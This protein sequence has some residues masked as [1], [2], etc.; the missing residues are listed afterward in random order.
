MRALHPV[1]VVASAEQ[2]GY[3]SP[4]ATT[5]ACHPWTGSDRPTVATEN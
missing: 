1:A 3:D 5:R 2:I 4:D